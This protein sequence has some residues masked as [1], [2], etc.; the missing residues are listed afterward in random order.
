MADPQAFRDLMR[1]YPTGVTVITMRAGE[2]QH[3]MT[4][5]A[6]TALSLDPL[7]YLICVDRSARA[8]EHLPKAGHFVVNVLAVDQGHVSTVFAKKDLT[9]DER[10]AEVSWT[11]SSLGARKIDGCTGYLECRVTDVL[12]GGDHS[13]FLGEV[14]GVQQGADKDPLVFYGG[15]YRELAA[16]PDPLG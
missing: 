4:A 15:A 8:H 6:V 14:V 5:N 11:D 16:V 1:R 13:I 9:D 7:L 10:W 12:P 3:G 2:V